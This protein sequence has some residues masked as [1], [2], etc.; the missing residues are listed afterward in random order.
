MSGLFVFDH[1]QG[2][3]EKRISKLYLLVCILEYICSKELFF[4]EDIL[5]TPSLVG[6]FICIF[7]GSSI[8]FR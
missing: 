6:G 4:C 8:K 7:V 5:Q 2:V 3:N 1:D